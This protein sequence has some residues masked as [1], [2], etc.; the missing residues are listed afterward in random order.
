MNP[1]VRARL[2]TWYDRCD[3]WE[4]A[5]AA[6]RHS[7]AQAWFRHRSAGRLAVLGYHGVEDAAGFAAH[8]DLLQQRCHPVSIDQVEEACRGGRPLPPHS[9]LIT[10]DDGDPTVHGR[11]L[12][13]LAA[14]GIPAV[15]F[16]IPGLI[17]TD[18]PFWW[19]EVEH[20]ARHGGR[21]PRVPAAPP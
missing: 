2:S 15:C 7:P 1:A 16:V 12:P 19:D 6:L 13:Q 14:R 8:L 3:A 18:Q 10:F 21:T 20:L 9:V 5:D 4:G 11:A 17:G